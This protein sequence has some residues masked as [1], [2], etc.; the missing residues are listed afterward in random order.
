[1]AQK[2]TR[3]CNL[4]GPITVGLVFWILKYGL[5]NIHS[6]FFKKNLCAR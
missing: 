6:R 1:V 3:K 4:Q 5:Q 2:F